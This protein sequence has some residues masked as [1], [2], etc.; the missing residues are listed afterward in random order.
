MSVFIFTIESLQQLIFGNSEMTIQFLKDH[1]FFNY[2]QLGYS[3]NHLSFL[4]YL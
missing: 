2:E 3:L 4:L 1:F